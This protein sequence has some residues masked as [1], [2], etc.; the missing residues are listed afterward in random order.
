MY[1]SDVQRAKAGR[2]SHGDRWWPFSSSQGSSGSCCLPSFLHPFALIWKLRTGP[3]A[4]QATP[5][6][7][8]YLS[9]VQTSLLSPFFPSPAPQGRKEE[10]ETSASV[11]SYFLL[12]FGR[13]RRIFQGLGVPKGTG[14]MSDVL[15]GYKILKFGENKSSEK[16]AREVKWKLDVEGIFQE[17]EGRG[18]QKEKR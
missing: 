7:V 2:V 8:T 11:F 6:K 4:F 5:S 10:A 13:R 15:G 3:L 9:F 14:H 16:T 18:H 17:T 12:Q 1:C